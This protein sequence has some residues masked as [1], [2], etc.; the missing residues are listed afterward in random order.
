MDP[1]RLKG[2]NILITGAARGMGEANAISFASQGANICI[3]DLEL[4]DAQKV[5]DRIN[6][7]GNGK[8]SSM[9]V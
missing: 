5:A 3:G 9:P 4:G 7:D 1:T 6:A 8:A 2:K